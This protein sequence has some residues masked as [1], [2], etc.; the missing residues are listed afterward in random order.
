MAGY[1]FLLVGN[2]GSGKDTLMRSAI[3][4]WPGNMV[5]MRTASR[6]ITRP[7]H[8]SE[9][10][11]SISAYD[12]LKQ[13]KANNVA[14]TWQSY[15]MNYG[16]PADIS[17]W[18]LNGDNVIINVSRK[19][20]PYARQKYT[21]TKVV[22]VYVPLQLTIKRIKQRRREIESDTGFHQRIK[23]AAKHLTLPDADFRIDNSGSVEN[24]VKILRNY[25]ISFS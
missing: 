11:I 20:I 21:Q 5:P 13:V 14:L 18:L 3:R 22:F 15:G 24:N 10:S 4:N 2:S 7:T 8:R 17:E 23:R 16:I 1:L 6:F 19:I 9:D 12:F 25:L